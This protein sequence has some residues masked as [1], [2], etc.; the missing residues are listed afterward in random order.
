MD[1]M[2]EKVMKGVFFMIMVVLVV[3]IQA[4]VQETNPSFSDLSLNHP[5]SLIPFSHSPPIMSIAH[6]NDAKLQRNHPKKKNIPK[7]K[8][9][10]A[11]SLN[12]TT[13]EKQDPGSI[14]KEEESHNSKL[15]NARRACKKECQKNDKEFKRGSGRYPTMKQEFEKCMND[16]LKR[17]MQGPYDFEF[18]KNS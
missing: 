9:N 5:P 1:V 4:I 3:L 11:S 7:E 17:K 8:H 12:S 10:P 18:S 16:C 2:A 13:T 15:E 6:Y 14:N